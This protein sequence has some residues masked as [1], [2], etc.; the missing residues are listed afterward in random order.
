MENHSVFIPDNTPCGKMG[1]E[2][3]LSKLPSAIKGLLIYPA[4]STFVPLR[5]R[6]E[7]FER[8]SHEGAGI[9][10]SPGVVDDKP[11]GFLEKFLGIYSKEFEIRQKV[12]EFQS[13]IYEGV[14]LG[15]PVLATG[16]VYDNIAAVVVGA[17]LEGDAILR[18]FLGMHPN[19]LPA[20]LPVEIG[21]SLWKLD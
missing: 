16:L 13:L 1:L 21:Y 3:R 18:G 15:L 19:H 2:D 12:S 11:S 14:L 10:V 7:V 6:L 20:S 5:K 17:V 4:V 8:L 9:Q